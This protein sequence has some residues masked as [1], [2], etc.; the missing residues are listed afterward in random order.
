MDELEDLLAERGLELRGDSRL[1]ARYVVEGIGDAR[2][3]AAAMAEMD[4]FWK[5]TGY[6]RALRVVARERWPG[7]EP[8]DRDDLSAVAKRRALRWLVRSGDEHA[9][10]CA[11]RS[12]LGEIR[13]ARRAVDGAA[14]FSARE[15]YR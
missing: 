15:Y 6:R 9:L 2:A 12:L 4:W 1:C 8:P 10:A 14:E 7:A 13:R 11:P 3:V 5:H